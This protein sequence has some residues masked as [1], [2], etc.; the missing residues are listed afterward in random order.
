MPTPS[1]I[2]GGIAT[3]HRGHIRFV[4]D[5]DMTQVKRFY[6][7]ENADTELIRGWRAHRTEQR[8]FYVL[9]GSFAMQTVAIDDWQQ[10]SRTLPIT[11][12][13]LRA[14]DQRI[15]HM[16]TGY[17]TTFQALEP[18]SQLLVF[19]DFPIEHAKEDDHTYP[20]D[21]FLGVNLL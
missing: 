5:F 20:I 16:P 10:P 15:I 4:N 21:Y 2:P 3:D 11:K 17:G 19:A 13:I 7:I 6:I 14:Q 1:F 18:G 12:E 8:W 9:Q